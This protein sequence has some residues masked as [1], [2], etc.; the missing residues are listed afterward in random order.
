MF[1][2]L[3]AICPVDPMLPFISM[4]WLMWLMWL[5]GLFGKTGEYWEERWNKPAVCSL[6]SLN[7]VK[8]QKWVFI[9]GDMCWLHL[10]LGRVKF[11]NFSKIEI[12]IMK[13]C[14]MGRII[15]CENNA[16]LSFEFW[17]CLVHEQIT[18]GLLTFIPSLLGK[19]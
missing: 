18:N 8:Y 13:S 16:T 7:E 11:F 12:Y 17:G 10:G 6:Q 4:V 3:Q 14:Y 1:S 5:M 15:H 2:N 9:E 19:K